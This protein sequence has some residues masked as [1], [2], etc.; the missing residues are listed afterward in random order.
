MILLV[1]PPSLPN[2][3]D[4]EVMIL[5]VFVKL[6]AGVPVSDHLFRISTPVLLKAWHS[7]WF[8]GQIFSSFLFK[9]FPLM[10]QMIPISPAPVKILPSLSFPPG[11]PLR[12]PNYHQHLCHD[13]LPPEVL[14]IA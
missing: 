10:L 8:C 13:C 7:T 6:H 2:T 4:L 14:L 12:L 1:C 5:L 11:A 9:T 3:S